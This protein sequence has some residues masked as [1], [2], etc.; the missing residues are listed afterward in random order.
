MRKKASHYLAHLLLIEDFGERRGVFIMLYRGMGII[1]A[2]VV[3][4]SV[5]LAQES[6]TI[7]HSTSTGE[8]TRIFMNGQ[9]G[10]KIPSDPRTMLNLEERESTST[11]VEIGLS[12]SIFGV[13]EAEAK[14]QV[15][16]NQD[17]AVSTWIFVEGDNADI[18]RENP[19]GGYYFD[20]GNRKAVRVCS[21]SA[22]LRMASEF[23]G[24]VFI[25]G[26]GVGKSKV[27]EGVEEIRQTSEIV[28]INPGDSPEVH[29][30]AC[31][32]FADRK[33]KAIIKSLK[34]LAA[35]KIYWDDLSQCNPSQKVTTDSVCGSWHKTLFPSVV[36]WTVPV[37][38]KRVGQQNYFCTIRS[39]KGGSCSIADPVTKKWVTSGMFEYPCAEGLF[40]KLTQAPGWFNY[41]KAE[42]H[43]K[44]KSNK[45]LEEFRIENHK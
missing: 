15:S 8:F 35:S 2:A 24:K 34:A 37:C 16:Y 26:G 23:L 25:L 14:T 30:K 21:V 43:S 33:H 31:A 11:K 39:K 41:G 20:P 13:I 28:V 42:C 38:E 7:P 19:A 40:C 6:G 32:D 9:Q 17:Y 22:S 1:V 3:F 36:A 27:Y 12:T 10:P 5:V 4:Q 45:R 18:I 44:I 29:K